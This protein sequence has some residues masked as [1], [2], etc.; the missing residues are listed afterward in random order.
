LVAAVA[1][2]GVLS[3]T[4][5]RPV[6]LSDR[7]IAVDELKRALN[8][9]NASDLDSATRVRAY[10]DGLARADGLLRRSI[11]ANPMDTTSI[12][13]LA[14]VRWESSVLVGEPDIQSVL[15]LVDIATAHAPRVPEIQARPPRSCDE[16][17]H[18]PPR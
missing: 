1:V 7:A 18:S 11:R 17:S 3:V 14:V 8:L 4:T 13:R 12:Q 15:S 10:S 6:G 16:P 2:F 9:L 5:Y